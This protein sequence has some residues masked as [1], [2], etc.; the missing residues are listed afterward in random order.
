M[1][2]KIKKLIEKEQKH[3]I[4]KHGNYPHSLGEWILIIEKQLNDAKIQWYNPR[5]PSNTLR[6]IKQIAATAISALDEFEDFSV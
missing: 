6:E 2:E 4:E 3:Q 1:T 5:S